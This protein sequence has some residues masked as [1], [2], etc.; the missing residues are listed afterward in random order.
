M[1][2]LTADQIIEP[3]AAFNAAVGGAAAFL[4]LH[5]DQLIAFGVRA[6]SPSTLVGWQ[7]LGDTVPFSR[8]RGTAGSRPLR[9]SPN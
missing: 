3:A 5:P 2:V 8:L 9:K 1:L 6:A 7:K 4:E